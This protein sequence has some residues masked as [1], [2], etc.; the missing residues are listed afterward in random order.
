FYALRDTRTPVAF[1]VL[2]MGLNLL[3]SLLLRGPLGYRGLAL[4]LSLAVTVEAA[5]LFAVLRLRLGGLEEPALLGT[6]MRALVAAWAMSVLVAGWMLWARSVPG[7]AQRP[8]VR[9]L[10]EVAGGVPIGVLAFLLV[11]WLAGANE[12][13]LLRRRTPPARG[14]GPS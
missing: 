7:L 14:G 6:V 13:R 4:A 1:A 2:S 9:Y 5:C 11:A 12:L 3:F 10:V 8:V